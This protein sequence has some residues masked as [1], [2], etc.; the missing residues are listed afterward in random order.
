MNNLRKVEELWFIGDTC[1]VFF[2][3]SPTSKFLHQGHLSSLKTSILQCFKIQFT[4]CLAS[5]IQ[6]IKHPQKHDS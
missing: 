2:M 3:Q 1:C 6:K 5:K 4:H